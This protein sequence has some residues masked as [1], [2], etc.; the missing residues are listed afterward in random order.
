MSGFHRGDSGDSGP[1]RASFVLPMTTTG[2]VV[3]PGFT[4]YF[5]SSLATTMR[6]QL[7]LDAASI[8]LP[9]MPGTNIE[10]I[11]WVYNPAGISTALIVFL[12]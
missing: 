6:V 12:G 5:K 9:V 7:R 1:A 4:R 2:V 11:G 8:D 3:I 10:D